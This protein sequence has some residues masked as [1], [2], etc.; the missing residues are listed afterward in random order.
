M[1]TDS[2]P[3][4]LILGAAGRMGGALIRGIAA[5]SETLRLG[6]AVERADS[7]ALG[8]D[9][10]VLAG[11]GPLGVSVTTDL[12]AALAVS[13]VVIDFTFHTAVPATIAAAAK[14]G[15][16]YVLGTTALDE[17]ETAVVHEAARAIPVVW[18]ANMSLGVNVLLDL[19]QRAASLLGLDYDAEIVEMHHRHK[20]DAPSGTALALGKALAEGRHQT[21]SEVAVH[22]RDGLTGERPRG[23]IAFHALRGGDVVG[24]HTIVFATEGERVELTHKASGRD[25]FAGGALLAATWLQG[26][27]AGL[28]SMRDVLGLQ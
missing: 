23:E 28:Y 27:A 3:S 9:A 7:P 16:A 1:N 2:R 19:V 6:A 15:R 17:A 12:E 5:R 18:A 4:I 11:C 13:D 26:K 25:C 22:G 8:Q 14:A 10:G 20:K 21:L 24:D